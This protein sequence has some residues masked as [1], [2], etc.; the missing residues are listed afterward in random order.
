MK[1]TV[2]SIII[3]GILIGGAIL[4]VG[5]GG[6]NN[7]SNIS[8]ASSPQKNN[9]SVEGGKQVIDILAR[10][11]Y[12]PKKT[13]AKSNA[14][15]TLRVTT[16][17]SFDCSVALSIPSIGYRKNLPSTSVTEIDIPPQAPGSALQGICAMGMYNF[18]INFD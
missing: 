8:D 10:G 9:V 15:T 2:I 16:K 5:G 7:S 12:S 1:S 3:A 17:G 11:G 4:L 14:T 13:I 18:I 6:Q